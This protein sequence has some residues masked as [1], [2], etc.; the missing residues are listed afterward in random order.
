MIIQGEKTSTDIF[1]E[2]MLKDF[3]DTDKELLVNMI[4]IFK[5]YKNK[6]ET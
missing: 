4:N 2:N 3:T 5:L 6:N 1:I